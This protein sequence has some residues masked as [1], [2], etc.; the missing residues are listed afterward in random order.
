MTE[1]GGVFGGH[2]PKKSTGRGDI[3]LAGAVTQ[4][5]RDNLTPEQALRQAINDLDLDPKVTDYQHQRSALLN[6]LERLLAGK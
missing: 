6:A 4:S 1:E 3:F 5:E 2:L